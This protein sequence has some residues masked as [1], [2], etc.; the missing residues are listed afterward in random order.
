MSVCHSYRHFLFLEEPKNEK[1]PYYFKRH[2]IGIGLI[3][4]FNHINYKL[5][6]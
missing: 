3:V 4:K 2:N 5:C 6:Q 1:M